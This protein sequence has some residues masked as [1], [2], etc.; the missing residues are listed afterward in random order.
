[1]RQP[2]PARLRSPPAMRD[3]AREPPPEAIDL[4]RRVLYRDGLVLVIDKPAGLP[5]H[6]GPKGGP[7]LEQFLDALRYG[8]PRRPALAHRLD[9]DTSGCLVLGRHPSALR[10]LGRLFAT[11]AVEKTYWAVA[12]GRP[13]AEQG[14]IDL[15][16]AKRSELR[17]WWMKVDPAGQPA[18]TLWRLLG[19]ADGLSWLELRPLTGRTHQIRVHLEALGCPVL[20]DPIYGRDRQPSPLPALHLHA[21]AILLPL[22]EKKP[23]IRVEA[24]PPPHMHEA[25]RACGWRPE[26]PGDAPDPRA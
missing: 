7:N 17:G 5:V 26:P 16:L 14:R 24:P 23:P 19:T 18:S 13:E 15:P 22:H 2:F 1:M 21:R 3:P 10:R 25:L 9:R 6:A 8:Y 4:E 20:G 12:I 11:G